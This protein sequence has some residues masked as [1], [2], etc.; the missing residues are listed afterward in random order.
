M[1]NLKPQDRAVIEAVARQFSATY[2]KSDNSAD[3]FITVAGKRIPVDV[4]TLKSR[5]TGRAGGAP[6]RLRFDKVVTRI[7]EHLQAALGKTVPD[8]G[9]VL[10]TI[11]API[12]V[13]SKTASALEAK[14]QTLLRRG[15]PRR[16]VKEKIFGNRIRIRF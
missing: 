14:M 10:L 2:E 8:G 7:M 1:S 3:A 16:D 9:I 6:P 15:S 11:T 5:A 4:A 12:R 13:A